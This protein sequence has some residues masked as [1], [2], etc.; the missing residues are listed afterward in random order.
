M[1]VPSVEAL[2]HAGYATWT[3][4][5][6]EVIDGWTVRSNGGFTR[7][8]N[9]ATV[10]GDAASTSIGTRDRIASWLVDRSAALAIR[11]TPLVGDTT[12]TEVASWG[13][14]ER[15]TTHVLVAPAR[16]ERTDRFTL[17]APGDEQFTK[18]LERLNDRPDSSAGAWRR[19]LGRLDDAVGLWI[20][21]V[22]VAL[23]ARCDD[24][25]MVY[26][27]AVAPA[28]RRTGLGTDAMRAASSWAHARNALWC[29]LQVEGMNAPALSLYESLG[30]RKA[31]RYSYLQP[32]H[33]VA[34]ASQPSRRNA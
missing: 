29:A 7:R 32:A 28:H 26:S 10:V 27:V 15:D 8:V 19:L 9:S 30:F 1:S 20:P 34:D 12:R 5:T 18:D 21:D 23:A 6:E 31:Y 2:E 17:V 3:A 14:V 25:V 11:L 13:L 24:I 16:D 22:A 4:D 33:G